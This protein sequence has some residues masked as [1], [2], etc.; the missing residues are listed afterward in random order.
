MD[1]VKIH[2]A[3]N[4]VSVIGMP[5]LLLLLTWGV[6]RRSDPIQRLAVCWIAL[7]SAIAIALKFTGDFA[8]DQAGP[9][10]DAVRAYVNA[11]EQSADQATAFVFLA[12]VAAA[13]GV[14]L[15][16]GARPLPKWS[17]A[18]IIFTV[19]L[20]CVMLARTAHIGGQIS[21]PELR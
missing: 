6:I 7:F 20:A 21:H 12:G 5:F 16:R 11:H 8:A 17:L 2:L 14:Y 15:A 13:L 3:L 19:L 10:L 18:L 1:W 9:K 4:H